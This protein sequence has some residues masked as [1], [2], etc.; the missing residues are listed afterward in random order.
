[1]FT[2]ASAAVKQEGL[3]DFQAGLS[4][5]GK[6]LRSLPCPI[7]PKTEPLEATAIRSC[8]SHTEV[9][10]WTVDRASVNSKSS[11]NSVSRPRA[12][13]PLCWLPEE[14]SFKGQHNLTHGDG[15]PERRGRARQARGLCRRAS[16][17]NRSPSPKQAWGHS[18][19][20]LELAKEARSL[21][22]TEG[23][24]SG[25]GQR[26]LGPARRR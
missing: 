17:Q 23:E 21:P 7:R 8:K 20:K 9:S 13:G 3:Q 2:V 6:N 15:G 11:T 25:Q 18:L 14:H 1:M 19:R 12:S 4:S 26:G 22:R 16:G 24:N 10:S 5:R